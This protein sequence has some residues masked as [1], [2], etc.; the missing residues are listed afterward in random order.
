M[1]GVAQPWVGQRLY[2]ADANAAY[3]ASPDV[4][5]EKFIIGLLENSP[6]APTIQPALPSP[7]G[8]MLGLTDVLPLPRPRHTM[9]EC[10]VHK[11][12]LGGFVPEH[13]VPMGEHGEVLTDVDIHETG[14]ISSADFYLKYIAANVPV[15][16]RGEAAAAVSHVEWVGGA[17]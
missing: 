8:P 4:A 7:G 13:T 16:L 3:A 15:I 1:G 12:D 17:R 6:A 10:H 14:S 9:R 5:I 2:A 11:C